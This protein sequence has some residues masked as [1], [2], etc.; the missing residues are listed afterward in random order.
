MKKLMNYI[1]II[2]IFIFSLYYTEKS[3]DIL[4][5]KDPIMNEIKNNLDKYKVEPV[6]AVIKDN[7]ITPGKNGQE[8][9]IEKTYSRMRK[10]GSY[11]EGLTKIKERKPVISITNNYDKYIKLDNCDNKKVALLFVINK[12]TNLNNLINIL[13]KNNV[14]STLYIESNLI[15]ENIELLKN[16]KYEIE[17]LNINKELFN[18]TKT[19]LETITNQEVKYCFTA[20]EDNTLLNLCQKNKMHT[21][22]PS[23]IIKKDLYKN[24]KSNIETSPIIAI[25]LNNYLE[26]ELTTTID[27]LKKKGYKFYNLNSLLSEDI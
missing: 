27:Y 11:N 2:I 21:I 10:Y 22:I 16:I 20:S 1:F 8:V 14:N 7:T 18:S 25:Y 23:L 12:D 17:L 13:D 19:Y 15:E 5:L 26:K 3:M 9:D 4:K 6:N 24:I